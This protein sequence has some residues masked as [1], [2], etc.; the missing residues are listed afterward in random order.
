LKAPSMPDNKKG[1]VI[2]TGG[3]GLLGLNWGLQIRNNFNVIL[4]LHQ[5]VIQIPG[6]KS[7]KVDLSSSKNLLELARET[8]PVLIVH[9]AGLT[10]IEE[11]E[12]NPE[13][14]REVNVEASG[15]VS[16]VCKNLQIPMIHISTDNLFDGVGS[17][18]DENHPINPVNVYG[19]TK[20]EAEKTILDIWDDV[21]VVRTNFYGW[22]P[23][24]KSSFSDTIINSL[25]QGKA[26]SLFSDVSYTPIY[27][28]ILV[29]TAH[30][31]LDKDGRGIFHVVGDEKLSKF[32]FGKRIA[33]KFNLDINLINENKI[34]NM[35][36]LADRP[37]DM[38]L[39]N[40]KVSQFLGKTLGNVDS[41]LSQL[42]TDETIPY[43]TEIR[44]L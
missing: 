30:Q 21:V 38:S 36:G 5:R 1:T 2:I 13:L 20:A 19:K 26:I 6:L 16:E 8:N 9:T 43:V 44:S 40:A 28:P 15:N 32:E 17:L 34:K 31:I 37:M 33:K 14:A 29:N 42:F 18:V 35:T 39:S 3:A 24:Y 11:C 41:Q 25:R 4:A 23:R 7:R 22:G 27:I 10:N 12:K